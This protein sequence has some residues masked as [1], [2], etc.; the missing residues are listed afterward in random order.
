M[1][2]SKPTILYIVMS[3]I[4]AFL[5]ISVYLFLKP[6]QLAE[7]NIEQLAVVKCNP[8]TEECEDEIIITDTTQLL[9]IQSILNESTS[10]KVGQRKCAS[11]NDYTLTIQPKNKEEYTIGINLSSC[12]KGTLYSKKYEGYEFKLDD[13]RMSKLIS[14]F[15]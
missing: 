15:E 4:V 10:K 11:F 7:N 6:I 8:E 1:N 9:S 13:E 12:G 5:F 2:M 14:L 3:I